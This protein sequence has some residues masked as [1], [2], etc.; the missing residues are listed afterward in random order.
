M[1]ATDRVAPFGIVARRSD[2]SIVE[3]RLGLF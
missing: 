3:H 1:R 2:V